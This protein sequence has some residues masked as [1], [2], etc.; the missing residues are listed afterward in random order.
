[1]RMKKLFVLIVALCLFLTAQAQ[2][3]HDGDQIPQGAVVYSLPQTC[4]RIVAYAQ[5]TQFTPGPYAKYARKF[6]GIDAGQEPTTLYELSQV[7]LT[8]MLEAD[9]H[10]MYVV[11][12]SGKTSSTQFLQATSQ[13]LVMLADTYSGQQESWRFPSQADVAHVSDAGVVQSLK[14][15]RTTLFR[16]EIK[17]QVVEPIAVQQ[18]QLVEKPLEQR[19]EEAA[20]AIFRLRSQRTAIITGDTDATYSGEAMQAAIDEMRRMEQEY[21][22]LFLGASTVGMSQLAVDV[23]P[24]KD[25]NKIIAFRISPTE[26]LLPASNVAGRPIVLNI[27]DIDGTKAPEVT[28]TEGGTRTSVRV[29][30]RQPVV[31]L[32]RLL[33]GQQELLQTRTPLYQ[34]GTVFGFPLN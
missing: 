32:L 33:D 10:Q 6:L 1:M 15:E 2:E 29:F 34:F 30:Y 19:A 24:E 3:V 18:S 7:E 21:L 14:Q 11:T 16:P 31:K 28:T 8:P 26:G 9:P 22:R 5:C 12:L 4:I 25:K 13:G 27:D 20:A 17:G 23:L